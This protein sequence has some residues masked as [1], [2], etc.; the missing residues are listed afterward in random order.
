MELERVGAPDTEGMDFSELTEAGTDALNR[1]YKWK[2]YGCLRD[3]TARAAIDPVR[4]AFR[5][6]EEQVVCAYQNCAT[7]ASALGRQQYA[8]H[9]FL[10]AKETGATGP[11]FFPV[12]LERL[13]STY[14]RAGDID[15]AR[16]YADDAVTE[17]ERFGEVS[18][19]GYAYMN[20]ATVAYEDSDLERAAAYYEKAYKAY[21]RADRP[22]ECGRSLHNLAQVHFDLGRY[23]A[24]RRALLAAGKVM[25]PL[26]QHRTL[27]L[28]RIL[29]G[30]LDAL[31]SHQDRATKHWREAVSIAKRLDDKVLRFKAEY[32]LLK[33][34]CEN[35]NLPVARSIQRRLRKLSNWVPKTTPELRDFEALS[36]R[37]A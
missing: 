24:S 5:D 20:R 25:Q 14:R 37:L 16:R 22:H 18:Y 4:P 11:R 1:G 9:E 27:A 7:A 33:Q 8:L 12:L 6:V 29:M 10:F 17:A 3:S 2:A 36:D 23:R 34:A 13:S 26:E 28:G 32:L 31:E 19:L 15:Q 21:Q 35:G 30:E